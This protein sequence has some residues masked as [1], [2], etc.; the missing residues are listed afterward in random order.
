MDIDNLRLNLKDEYS[1]ED[2]TK[3]IFLN[4]IDQVFQAHKNLG[5]T[6]LIIYLGKCAGETCPN[7]GKK[8]Y[9]FVGNH[10]KNYMDLIFEIEGDD[11]LDFFTCCTFKTDSDVS[12]SGTKADIYINLDDQNSFLKT[13]EYCAKV[14]SAKTAWAEIIT[15]PPR[16]LNFE[17]LSFWI[18]KYSVTNELIGKVDPFESPMKWTPFSLLYN[19]LKEIR[20][21]LSDHIA[22][23]RTAN[24][25]IEHIKTEKDLLIWLL[26]YEGIGKNVPFYLGYG[27]K[28][29]GDYFKLHYYDTIHFKD[30]I[31]N[32]A[33]NFIAYF[34][35][36]HEE[37]LDKYTVFTHEEA[38]ILS[39]D[40]DTFLLK[41][42]LEYRK[43][44]EEAGIHTPFYIN[45]QIDPSYKLDGN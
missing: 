27:F 40:R 15:I 2:T 28:E 4:E 20:Y 11:I 37:M 38:S 43:E 21:Y 39:V 1:Y 16:Q 10:S 5:D 8:G 29:E 25:E 12:E 23:I 6:E 14:N 34:Q 17:E 41:Y 33:M 13:P 35:K 26:N 24:S 9:R 7:C 22:E 42:H 30:D 36:Q 3:E 44:K 31:F 32:D 45:K 18:D 19:D